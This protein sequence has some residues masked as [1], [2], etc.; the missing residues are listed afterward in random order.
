MP[1]GKR[2]EKEHLFIKIKM[3]WKRIDSMLEN[4]CNGTEVAAAMGVHPDTLYN[5]VKEKF[6]IDFS[7]Y[8]AQ[9]RAA[10]CEEIRNLQLDSARG[11][12]QNLITPSVPMQIWLGKQYLEQKDKH[13]TELNANVGV[14]IVELPAKKPEGA[15]VSYNTEE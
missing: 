14:S 5:R 2:V 13:E 9:K 15:P 6:G 3:D 1:K 7:A 4:F 12:K 10:G 11:D 8:R